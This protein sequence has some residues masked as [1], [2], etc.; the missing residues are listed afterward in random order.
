M[1]VRNS[2]IQSCS[3]VYYSRLCLLLYNIVWFGQG[4][5]AQVKLIQI[6]LQYIFL[7]LQNVQGEEKRLLN[8][9]EKFA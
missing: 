5:F 2:Y 1:Y 4:G 6:I 7:Y 3:I 8:V 9:H